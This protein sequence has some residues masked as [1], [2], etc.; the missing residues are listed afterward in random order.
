MSRTLNRYCIVGAGPAGLVAARALRKESIPFDLYERHGDVGG[1]WDP[2]NPGSPMY[3]SAH[4]ISSK[5]TSAFYGYPMPDHY[6]DYPT[7]RQ[8]LEY[9]RGFA[10]EYRL[11]DH[12][13]FNTGVEHTALE[14]EEWTVTLD[15]GEQRRYR[16][17]ICANGT[18][19]HPNVP[20]LPGI[21]SFAGELRHS[22]TYRRPAEFRGRRVLII[23]AG[24]SGAD[25]ACDAAL[26]AERAFFSVRRGYRYVPKHIFGVPTDVFING[27][28][29]L[30][31]GIVA[32]EDPS[33]L[34]DALVGD[35]TR[36]GLPAPDHPALASHPIMNT[37]ILHHLS[38]GDIAAKPNVAEFTPTGV[39]FAD[40]SEEELDLVLLATGYEWR[41]PYVDQS[42]FEWK[43]N[44]PQL[45]LNIFHRSIDN[46]YALGMIEFAD[47]AYKRFDEMAQLVVGDIKANLTGEN[48]QR[49]RELKAT[50]HP[51]LRGGI[52]YID[53][54]RHAS[55]VEVHTY[56][57]VLDELRREL[58]WPAPDE[59]FYEQPRTP[60][61]TATAA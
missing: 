45:Y 33:E 17:L 14:G 13:T 57:H 2:D 1:I 32:P 41:I 48:K 28:A 11:Y 50:H 55:Y 24:N 16:G 23:G 56:M 25:I 52:D 21:D 4:F 53:S 44:H 42:V 49:L 35:L 51:D 26:N 29:E 60:A 36:Y 10:R 5:W 40:G 20:E 15:T 3:D 61:T 18:T 9:I 31:A 6:P 43:A 30:P 54:P 22:V 47:A 46:L 39:A 34:L 38:H 58:G 19:W 59:E 8:I 12:I 37:Q 7:S 27:G